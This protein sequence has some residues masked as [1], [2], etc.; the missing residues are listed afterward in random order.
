[1]TR[2]RAHIATLLTAAA[3]S[4]GTVVAVAAA[5]TGETPRTAVVI[6]AA[7]ARDGRDLVDSRLQSLDAEIRLPRTAT[8]AE[9]DVRYLDAQGY[10]IVV[11]GPTATEA[12]A[13]A[14]VHAA[15]TTG[16]QGA[17]VAAAD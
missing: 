6:D 7:A 10:R 11:A 16:L 3:L 17:L 15:S 14:G 8:E 4:A 12:A 5:N 2:S 1:M 9:T 13:E